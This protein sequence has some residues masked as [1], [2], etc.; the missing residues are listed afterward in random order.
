MSKITIKTSRRKAETNKLQLFAYQGMMRLFKIG[1]QVF[2]KE[3]ADAIMVDS[4]MSISS[5]IP[6]SEHV[7]NAGQRSKYSNVIEAIIHGKGPTAGNQV[8]DS[9]AY[10]GVEK[11][12]SESHGRS[13]GEKAY[14]LDLGSIQSPE[15]NL[16]FEVVVLQHALH[17]TG[18]G[19][20]KSIEKG[21]V[22][23]RNF[24][25]ANAS[26]YIPSVSEWLVNGR[27]ITRA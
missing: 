21:R 2:V 25:R 19:A 14:D 3:A 13:L 20:W 7:Q 24:I 9:H 10:P 18:P 5:L 6:L 1:V 12:K 15:F 22:A 23:M 16:T 11:Y 8:Y 27:P 26:D 4:G 17:D